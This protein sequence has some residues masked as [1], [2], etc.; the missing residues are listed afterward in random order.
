MIGPPAFAGAVQAMSRALPLAATTVGAAGRPGASPE[1]AAGASANA[2]AKSHRRRMAPPSL[3]RTLADR[4]RDCKC[5]CVV[6][7]V[8]KARDKDAQGL[9]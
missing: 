8:C 9:E 7:A 5:V 4:N 3:R 1:A 6:N 2:A